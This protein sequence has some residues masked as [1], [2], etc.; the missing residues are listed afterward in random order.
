MRL[1]LLTQ[2]YPPETGAPQNRLHDLAKRMV[3]MGHRV[4]VLTA[5]PNYPAGRITQGYTGRLCLREQ[6]DDVDV[7]RCWIFATPSYGSTQQ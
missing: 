6:L 5:M 7:I 3:A 1:I 2:Y 4:T